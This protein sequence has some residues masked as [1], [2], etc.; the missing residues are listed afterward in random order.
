MAR[1]RKPTMI[2]LVT[3]RFNAAKH[4]GA[5]F[6]PIPEGTLGEA[7]AEWAAESI[8][9]R[10]WEFVLS[11]APTGMF[12]SLDR[13]LLVAWCETCADYERARAQVEANGCVIVT[14]GGMLSSSPYVTQRDR[15]LQRMRLLGD[16]LGF[17]PSARS[18]L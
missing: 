14:P 9:R 12:R 18:R 16:Q 17:S 1:P 10:E 3:N 8:M 15:A 2:R 5:A 4:G 6:E 7:P 13:R 11:H